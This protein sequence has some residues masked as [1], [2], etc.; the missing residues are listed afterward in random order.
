MGTV[1]TASM[2]LDQPIRLML[3][4]VFWCVTIKPY[5]GVSNLS[6]SRLLPLWVPKMVCK[7]ILKGQFFQN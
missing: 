1:H 5:Q 7:L 2:K 6:V 3:R 4:S